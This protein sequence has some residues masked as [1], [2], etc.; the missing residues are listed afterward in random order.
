MSY[1]IDEPVD[2]GGNDKGMTPVE[3]LLAAL[4]A[5]KAIVVRMFAD[6]FRINLKNYHIEVSGELDPDGFVG[7]A[8]VPSGFSKIKT[9]DHLEADN[10]QKQIDRFI[11]FVEEHCPVKATLSEPADM[12]Y[13]IK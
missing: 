5:C 10:E 8:D 9:I 3:S 4:G 1:I 7:K 6:K 13:E 12:E 2:A 11:K